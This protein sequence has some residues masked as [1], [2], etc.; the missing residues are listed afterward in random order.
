MGKEGG[1]EMKKGFQ[2]AIGEIFKLY[3]KFFNFFGKDIVKYSRA[4]HSY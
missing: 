2:W 3:F 1:E 4:L